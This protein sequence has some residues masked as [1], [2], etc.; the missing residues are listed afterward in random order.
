ME[1]AIDDE[2]A[3]LV[4]ASV[5]G[6]NLIRNGTPVPFRRHALDEFLCKTH[7]GIVDLIERNVRRMGA[8]LLE[9]RAVTRKQ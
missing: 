2:R 7:P 8:V 5:I 1:M 9:R 6:W 4:P 3:A